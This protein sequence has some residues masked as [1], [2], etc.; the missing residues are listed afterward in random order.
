MKPLITLL[1]QISEPS[2]GVALFA[3]DLE[4]VCVPLC[5]SSSLLPPPF[6]LQWSLASISI[7]SP[8]L[9]FP[10]C[11]HLTCQVLAAAMPALYYARLFSSRRPSVAWKL[12]MTKTCEKAE[13]TWWHEVD[14]QPCYI[15]YVESFSEE[16]LGKSTS[17]FMSS[18]K[19]CSCD[20]RAQQTEDSVGPWCL[21]H[22]R[23]L[24]LWFLYRPCIV[25]V[26]CYVE[27]R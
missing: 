15:K 3:G 21:R 14:I 2:F 27:T 24:G 8:P 18:M 13:N 4:A 1:P 16:L 17:V 19:S 9:C 10:A 12:S 22:L 6:D 26:H 25:H 7:F 23:W 20:S 11:L 5:S